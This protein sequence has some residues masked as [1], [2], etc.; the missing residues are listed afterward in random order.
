MKDPKNTAAANKGFTLIEVVVV[1]AIAV[2]VVGIA[3]PSY[4]TWRQSVEFRTS[5]RSIAAAL[6]DARSRAILSNFQHRIEF[7]TAP[8]PVGAT[9]RYRMTQGDRAANSGTWNTV[10]DWT[11]MPPSVTLNLMNLSVNPG[12]NS[13]DFN[14]SGTANLTVGVTNADIQIRD[15]TALTRFTVEVS[16]TGRVRIF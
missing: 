16:N 2:T 6:R 14:P 3:L 1:L 8:A 5:A 12:N 7:E 15:T 11:T 10:L 9:G 4:V 13:I